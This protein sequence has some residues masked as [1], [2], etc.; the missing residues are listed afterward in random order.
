MPSTKKSHAP[1]KSPGI[2]CFMNG[3]CFE[4]MEVSSC[5][6]QRM[7]L[8]KILVAGKL[9]CDICLFHK[10][11]IPGCPSQK[12]THPKFP[13]GLLAAISNLFAHGSGSQGE[14]SIWVLR[15]RNVWAGFTKGNQEKTTNFGKPNGHH[16]CLGE[17]KQKPRIVRGNQT[18]TAN[19]LG[20]AKLKTMS[21]A[22]SKL[23]MVLGM[24]FGF[25]A[26]CPR[27]RPFDRFCFSFSPFYFLG[28]PFSW[29]MKVWPFWD[30]LRQR[31]LVCW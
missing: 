22:H 3:G 9:L 30:Q 12:T 13:R 27:Q 8:Y 21:S 31:V 10:N 11:K 7:C 23:W 25:I 24:D 15:I 28:R 20:F 16:Y 18:E 26:I 17:T 6:I 29:P 14:E 5:S 2:H 1:S 19:C 4:G